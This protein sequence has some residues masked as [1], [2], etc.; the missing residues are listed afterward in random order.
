MP[1]WRYVPEVRRPGQASHTFA[2]RLSIWRVVVP[3]ALVATFA[4]AT[5][6][7]YAGS[8]SRLIQPRNGASISLSVVGGVLASVGYGETFQ[9]TLTATEAGA[10]KAGLVVTASLAS[11]PL[12]TSS[13]VGITSGT[14]DMAGDVTLNFGITGPA[15]A[16]TLT[17]S[18]PGATSVTSGTI[19][20]TVTPVLSITTQPASTAESGQAFTQTIVAGVTALNTLYP[21]E[22]VVVTAAIA[23]APSGASNLIATT[24]RTSGADGSV[25]FTG[26]GISGPVGDYTLSLSATGASTVTSNTIAVSASPDPDP[27]PAANPTPATDQSTGNFGIL[28]LEFPAGLSCDLT[29]NDSA[30]LQALWIQLPSADACSFS[31]SSSAAS[32]QLLGWATTPDFPVA[33]ARRQLANGWGAYELT[34]DDGQLTAVFIPAGGSTA[35][36][37]PARLFPIIDIAS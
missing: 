6:P 4:A 26:L 17:F 2:I 25:T 20:L 12:G 33:I 30:S 1:K 11:T 36:T 29:A 24:T 14:T 32:P 22:G 19:T 9:P 35:Q 10:P 5:I 7:A 15:G 34:N 23:S 3:A 18:A 21:L 13:L 8:D 16:Y 37:A 28:T 27:T 31:G